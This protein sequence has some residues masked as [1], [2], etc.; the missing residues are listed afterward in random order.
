MVELF[1]KLPLVAVFL[2]AGCASTDTAPSQTGDDRG[3]FPDL[4]GDGI[5]FVGTDATFTENVFV[6]DVAAPESILSLTTNQ[7]DEW[8][9]SG[10]QE[11]YYPGT[12]L[13]AT[14]PYGVP[15]P[16]ARYIAFVT[17][18]TVPT[19]PPVARVSLAE[20]YM[21]LRT[22]K[23]IVGLQQVAF[24]PSGE[25]LVLTVDDP[26]TGQT[27]LEVMDPKLDLADTSVSIVNEALGPT[28]VSDLQYEGRGRSPDTVLISGVQGDPGV[29]SLWEVPLPEGDVTLLTVD[30]GRDAL[31]PAVSPGGTFLAVELYDP[32][33]NRSDIAIL[34]DA[35]GEWTNITEAMADLDYRSPTWEPAPDGGDRLAFLQYHV[36]VEEEL[37][38]LCLAIRDES[39][40]WIVESRDIESQLQENRLLGTPRWR[41]GGDELL[42]DYRLTDNASGL[43]LAE[44]VMYD[45]G[46]DTAYV[47]PTDG[48]PEL[49]HWSHDGAKVLMWDRS[50]VTNS[51]SAERTPIRIYDDSTGRTESLYVQLPADDDEDILYIEYPL[52]LHHNT[53]WY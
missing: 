20:E 33:S 46:H 11:E 19:D 51:E 45:V 3:P 30:L 13:A 42:L 12:L 14:A 52:F 9:E 40:A 39:E 17:V 43:N 7:V 21:P 49:A 48:E 2:I 22:S 10:E 31:A 35:T 37:T 25:Y 15:D 32:E 34:D 8:P 38:Q 6:V 26:V 47:L 53:L 18:P 28:A 1:P 4:V 23:S 36:E 44:L 41:P 50:V 27:V 16:S 5:V 24:D 29:A